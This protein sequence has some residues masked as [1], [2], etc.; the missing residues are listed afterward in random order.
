[1]MQWI[2]KIFLDHGNGAMLRIEMSANPLRK[3]FK[4]LCAWD[5]D[6]RD[7]IYRTKNIDTISSSISSISWFREYS[8]L[9]SDSVSMQ[10]H[11]QFP[12]FIWKCWSTYMQSVRSLNLLIPGH[13]LSGIVLWNLLVIESVLTLF[14]S[15]EKY[16]Q[17]RTS[18]WLVP[19]VSGVCCYFAK[20]L[21]SPSVTCTF[22]DAT[23]TAASS[24]TKSSG[25]FAK[26][27]DELQPRSGLQIFRNRKGVTKKC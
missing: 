16:H 12:I 7:S 1:M 20:V 21:F 13:F 6:R 26:R 22:E 3:H 18:K 5:R 23:A 27:L 14:K 24:C 8:F 25:I 17:Y 4:H 19:S 9:V 11:G 2:F 15:K 10:P